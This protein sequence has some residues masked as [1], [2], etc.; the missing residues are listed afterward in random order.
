VLVAN[1]VEVRPV[2]HRRW[3]FEV[4]DQRRAILQRNFVFGL[5]AVR[6]SVLLEHDGFD[7]SILWTT[8]W[9]LW[10]RLILAGSAAGCVDEPLAEYRLSE[11]SLTARRRDL[12]LGKIGTLEKARHNPLLR[13]E[14]HAALEDSIASYRR[15]LA[16][17]DLTDALASGQ[18]GNRSRATSL[19]LARGF[20][21][22]R[23]VEL[24]SMALAPGLVG[25]VLRRRARTSWVGGGGFRVE[26]R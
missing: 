7:E 15:E 18:A 6:R 11:T 26:R 10:L 5:A 22:R 24:A 8:D 2:Y 1:G 16:F 19:L 3:R 23:R 13:A 14:E 25:R 17:Q 9:D 21:R 12:L 4:D 20:D